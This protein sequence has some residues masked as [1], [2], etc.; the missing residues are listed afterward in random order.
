MPLSPAGGAGSG[1]PPSQPVGMGSGAPVSQT[2]GAGSRAPASHFGETGAGR[3]SSAAAGAE[4][5]AVQPAPKPAKIEP[6][7]GD[8]F[9]V[10]FTASRAMK[11]K[12][13]L[14]CDLLRHANPKGDL[15]VVLER[16]LDLL[17]AQLE[18]TKQGRTKRPRNQP[19]RNGTPV[20]HEKVRPSDQQARA[21]SHEDVATK[22]RPNR[23]PIPR[24]TR[25][26]VVERDGWRCCFV[27]DDGRR[28]DA[29][30][31]V[32][33]DHETPNGLG[34]TSQPENL[35][36]LCRAHNRLAAERIYGKAYIAQAI[37]SARAQRGER[38]RDEG[39][40]ALALSV[41]ER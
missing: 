15:S 35:R 37:E 7:S 31:F 6:L 40:A 22:G 25:R 3:A 5:T 27:S 8:R 1:T 38:G 29:R 36:L 14:A 10:K 39:I 28:C 23:A 24:A 33:F 12:L 11:E 21:V 18:N 16:A 30:A 26:E 41:S 9:L 4:L 32:E 34:G 2:A 17:V 19:T 13:A 20:S